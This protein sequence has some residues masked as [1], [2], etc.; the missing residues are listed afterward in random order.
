MT[1]KK[2]KRNND[3]TRLLC[4]SL[5]TLTFHF[6]FSTFYNGDRGDWKPNHDWTC[7]SLRLSLNF[8]IHVHSCIFHNSTLYSAESTL[9][10]DAFQ[11]G[12]CLWSKYL[13]TPKESAMLWA[14]VGIKVQFS[15]DLMKWFHHEVVSTSTRD[16][17][18]RECVNIIFQQLSI[19]HITCATWDASSVQNASILRRKSIWNE[20]FTKKFRQQILKGAS[21]RNSYKKSWK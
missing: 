14:D 13:L 17:N 19:G 3:Q 9:A 11:H 21:Q 1:K 8:H 10:H 20:S 6:N 4:P 18:S 16:F 15:Y 7:L 5:F 12:V 2:W